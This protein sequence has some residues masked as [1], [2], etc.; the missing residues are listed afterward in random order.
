MTVESFREWKI[1]FE[2]EMREKRGSRPT[3]EISSKLTGRGVT[4]QLGLN[5]DISLNYVLQVDKCLNMI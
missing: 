4:P 1:K 2:E 3:V 5:Q